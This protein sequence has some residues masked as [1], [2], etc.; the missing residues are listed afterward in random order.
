MTRFLRR[1]IA[2]KMCILIFSTAFV[3]NISHSKKDSAR[4]KKI[5]YYYYIYY[6]HHHHQGGTISFLKVL[7]FST[8][9]FHL[10]RHCIHAVKLFIFIILKSSF[11]W[12][13]YFIFGL[14]AYLVDTSFHSY[15]ILTILSFAI[16][17]T[18]PNQFNLWT[19]IHLI[20]VSFLI[21][22]FNS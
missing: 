11:I 22:L 17:H 13:S 3:W 19:L 8:T 1:Y 18:W 5:T 2:Y 15:N 6:Y 12:F 4:Y 16:W 7:A 21:R 10:T 14:P 20:T 9:S